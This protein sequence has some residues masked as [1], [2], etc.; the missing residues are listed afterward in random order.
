M[1]SKTLRTASLLALLIAAWVFW[2]G[3]FQPLLLVL[4]AFSCLLTAYLTRRMGYFDND[5]FALRFGAKLFSY[6]AWL[7]REVWRSS[8]EVARVVVNPRLPI[9]PQIVEIQAT[10]SHPVDQAIL[11]NSI[12]L[13]PGTL[14][15]DVHRGKIQ[16]H[17]LTQAGADDLMSGEMDRRVAA[18]RQ[19]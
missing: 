1:S 2:S 6:W 10:A 17:C 15:L 4:G 18:L 13:T 14:A 3:Q 5:L 9:S 19:D 7:A 11:G 8:I 12:T 16:V